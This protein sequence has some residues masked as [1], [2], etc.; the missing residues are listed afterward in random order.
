MG[1]IGDV[2]KL[3]IRCSFGGGAGLVSFYVEH[4]PM[5]MVDSKKV[6][7]SFQFEE[8]IESYSFSGWR[9]VISQGKMVLHR[10]RGI[11]VVNF[12]DV[13]K[14]F[15][16]VEKLVINPYYVKGI[17]NGRRVFQLDL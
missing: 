11:A 10:G 15:W 2:L 4:G 13:K 9:V 16:G 5:S 3:K 6:R 8:G 17:S 12:Y 7:I 14:F 1:D